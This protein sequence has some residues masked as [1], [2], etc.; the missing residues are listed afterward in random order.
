MNSTFSGR[1]DFNENIGNWD[2]SSVTNMGR[3]FDQTSFNQP[4]GEW[5]T[6]SVTN[7]S[8]MFNS[9][10][11]NQPIGKW[12]TSS[13]T[14]MSN[15]FTIC[16]FD[17][18]IGD[19][20]VSS[21]TNFYGM[22]M[23]SSFNQNINNWNTSSATNMS[24]MFRGHRFNQIISDWNISSVTNMNS[25]FDDCPL[26][27]ASKGQIHE[28]FSSN[29]NWPYDW[30][31]F[32]P[33]KNLSATSELSILENQ[34][35]GTIVG[36]FNVTDANH[37]NIT[38]E[39]VSGDG[40]SL[41]TNGTLKTSTTFDYES[42]A[43]TYTITV[44]AKDELNAT[45]EG[46][47]TV[48]LL[49]QDEGEAP[50]L[51][52]GSTENPYQIAT[53]AN[54][55][56]LSM[57][58]SVWNAKFLQTADINASDTKNWNE[59]KGFKPIG[60]DYNHPFTGVY[61][62]SHHLITD[63]F[64]N[65]PNQYVGLFGYIEG[66]QSQV[67]RKVNLRNIN[68]TGSD[69]GSI[70][71][72]AFNHLKIEYCSSVDANLTGTNVG[73]LVGYVVMGGGSIKFSSF[74]GSIDG[75]E[76]VGGIAGQ[77]GDT[78]IDS[79]YAISQ[80]S[81]DGT[82]KGGIAGSLWYGMD[83]DGVSQNFSVS[84][85]PLYG[86]YDFYDYFE[87]PPRLTSFWDSNISSTNPVLESW[88]VG[89]TTQEM[90]TK[91]TF[92]DAGW[93]FNDTWFMPEHG[94]PI[95][96]WQVSDFPPTDLNSTTELTITENQPVGTIVGE[97]NAT[98]PEGGAITY[99]F[100]NGVNNNSFFTLDTNG[101]LK[102]ATAFDYESNAST[103][104]ITVKAKDELNASIEGNFTVTLL[105]VYE[106]SDGDGF[107]DSLEAST[108]SDLNDANSTPLQQ[109][110]VA[111]YPFDG[112]ASDMSG[113]E[114]HGTVYGATLGSDRF[115]EDGKSYNFDGVDDLY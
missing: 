96:R 38:Y 16:S 93:D 25:M 8:G 114:N 22:F 37:G 6:S 97:F 98:D 59:G 63:L 23:Y 86:S 81:Y 3:M 13:V 39:L 95:L 62:G 99:H 92:V 94:Y 112:N 34:P 61:D 10:D 5:N 35:I 44:K 109:G 31:E 84:N 27:N 19:W 67:V 11:F 87:E 72:N 30:S 24:E 55:K 70:V 53:L 45:T 100:V 75:K 15:M 17:R 82:I 115:G 105:D 110:L 2:T 113:N 65:R 103:Y 50:T 68:L 29:P 7:M 52:D 14:N 33:P 9:A 91:S 47:F 12:D 32:I 42:N 57:T 76:K 51:G 43:S 111:W 36:D 26:S 49:D 64:I 108:G 60:F 88:A 104:T 20:N 74:E 66:G 102:T 80:F 56:W 40:F 54:L 101:T 71:G 78:A 58:P 73:G 83:F 79:C 90:K 4:I 1:F 69:T 28:S 48:T 77:L 18:P 106:D 41:E 107:R 21:V 46:N 85:L 89:K